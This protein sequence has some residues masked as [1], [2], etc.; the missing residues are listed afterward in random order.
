MAKL[1]IEHIAKSY[2]GKSVLED[3]HI[4]IP[5]GELVSLL[6]PSGCGKTTTLN[7]VAGF[8]AP[9]HGRVILGDDDI[10]YRPP[11]KRDTAIVF[12]NYA[13][14]P[15]MRVHDNVAYGLR[16]HKV[17]KSVIRER[18]DATL[19]TM[20]IKELADRYPSQL[21]GGQQQRVAVARAVAVEPSALLMDEP[22]SNL[23]AKL[24][25][26]IRLELRS[27]QHR[28]NQTILF[29]THDQEEA[30]SISDRIVVMNKGH[31]EQ[32]GTPDEL[33]TRPRTIFVA[34]FMGVENVLH[35]SLKDGLWVGPGGFRLPI[36]GDV[37]AES[38]GLRPSEVELDERDSRSSTDAYASLE[39]TVTGRTYLGD[40][41][42][43]DLVFGDSSPLVAVVPQSVARFVEGDTLTARIKTRDLIPLED[44]ALM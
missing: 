26:E 1:T 24:R 35:G 2:G 44:P 13:L 12:Q 37:G 15:H 8:V 19:Q 39:V 34:N 38:I 20:G 27:L 40:T 22:L 23:D 7:I 32:I 6:G 36:A 30:L 21:S 41:V 42:R 18:V 33:F 14:F 11:Y 17:P 10:T 16:A 9:D 31:I 4:E 3:A 5:H 25:T 29:V 43:Y 28:L